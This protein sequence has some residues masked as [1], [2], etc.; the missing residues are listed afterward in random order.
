MLSKGVHMSDSGLNGDERMSHLALW[1]TSY[2]GKGKS[3]NKLPAMGAALGT[4]CSRGSN[5]C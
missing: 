3:T 2:P 4:S 1:R 5:G